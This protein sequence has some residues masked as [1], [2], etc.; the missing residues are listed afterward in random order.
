MQ[1]T[2]HLEEISRLEAEER[3]VLEH[4][5]SKIENVSDA[6]FVR[7]VEKLSIGKMLTPF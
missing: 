7:L 5:A 1:V 3:T 4:Y 2:L 6:D